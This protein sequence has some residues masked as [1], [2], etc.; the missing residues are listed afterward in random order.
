MAPD[1]LN[2]FSINNFFPFRLKVFIRICYFVTVL[3]H[4]L[5]VELLLRRWLLTT[6][7]D[8]G[9]A[10]IMKVLVC[11]CICRSV[12]DASASRRRLAVLASVR[13]LGSLAHAPWPCANCA[14]VRLGLTADRTTSQINQSPSIQ[15]QIILSPCPSDAA[16]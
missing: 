3:H 11:V 8:V 13:G 15:S 4:L 5:A 9:V 2:D 7:S 16:E 12:G 1:S 10:S 14:R 6:V